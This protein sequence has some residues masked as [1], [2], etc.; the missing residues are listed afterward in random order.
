MVRKM[1]HPKNREEN[2]TVID[3]RTFDFILDSV[4]GR[5]KDNPE[6]IGHAAVFNEY[7]DIVWW[8]ERIMP[9]AFKES[10]KKDDV[11]A[12]FNHDSNYILGRNKSGTLVL[13]E[14]DIGSSVR[15]APPDTQF[16]KDLV[17]LI[18]RGDISQM[19]FAFQVIEDA[20]EY[21]EDK[22]PDKRDMMKVRLFDVSPVTYPA[23]PTTDVS[24]RSYEAW[25]QELI[26][27]STP[28]LWKTSLLKRKLAL[29]AKGGYK[30]EY[31]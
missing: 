28:K 13:K 7:A 3:K 18:E 21:G 2:K 31:E 24:V 12:L 20:W 15:I 22:E 26:Q 16:A 25:Q 19:S 30:N 5:S 9:G 6:I 14:D 11:R 8:K 4:E 10:I 1:Q 23:Y 29:K 27:R 17:K